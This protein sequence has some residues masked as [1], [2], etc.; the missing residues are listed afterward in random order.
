MNQHIDQRARLRNLLNSALAGAS[1]ESTEQDGGLLRVLH[2]TRSGGRVHLR[3]L[4][5]KESKTSAE[6]QPG[7]VL[8]LGG[9]GG[10]ARIWEVF[11][12][13]FLRTSSNA[14]HVRIDAGAA[15]LEIVCEDVEWWE[16]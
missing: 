4:G 13:F 1:F 12:P 10:T 7:S 16:D 11:L 14:A 2:A 8:S 5:V 3:F 6:P 15:R 9:V